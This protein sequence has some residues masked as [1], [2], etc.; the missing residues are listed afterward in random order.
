MP[1]S[2]LVAG[3][4]RSGIHVSRLLAEQGL[5]VTVI[6]RLPHP[7]GQEPEPDT[8]DLARAARGSGVRFLLGT[9][10]V[11]LDG[12][13]LDTL[14]TAGARR[15]SATALVVATGSRPATL[16]ELG[17]TGDRCAGILPGSAA[18][19]LIEAGV[20]PGR[21]PAVLGSGDLAGHC[22]SLCLAAGAHSVSV[23][24][25]STRSF[26]VPAGAD[27]YD[28]WQLTAIQGWPRVGHVALSRDQESLSVPADAVL[29]AHERRPMRNIENAIQDGGI[30]VGCHS[31]ADPKTDADARLAAQAAAARVREIIGNRSPAGA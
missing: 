5:A 25:P 14:G 29:I 6:E 24:S 16:G 21:R 31:A 1:G 8:T 28:G 3:A 23:V 22:V 15:L 13:S 20:L 7:G 4:G 19:H 18:V 11:S 30:V 12:S 2:V 9:L 26:A 17:I 10:A 27:T